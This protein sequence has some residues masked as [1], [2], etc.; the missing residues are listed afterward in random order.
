MFLTH[1]RLVL[2]CKMLEGNLA[3]GEKSVSDTLIKHF[4]NTFR[5][6]WVLI[7]MY[8]PPSIEHQINNTCHMDHTD[9]VSG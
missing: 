8:L 6:E 4:E 3:A 5:R 7:H 9:S 2:L 1:S